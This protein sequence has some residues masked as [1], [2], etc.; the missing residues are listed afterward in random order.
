VVVGQSRCRLVELQYPTPVCRSV[1]R[2]YEV[3]WI[4]AERLLG[5][6]IN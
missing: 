3:V 6:R 5:Y 2:I 1:I 4:D